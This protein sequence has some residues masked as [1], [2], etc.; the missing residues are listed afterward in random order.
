MRIARSVR[1]ICRPLAVWGLLVHCGLVLAADHDHGAS[2][3][4]QPLP[5][6]PK[7]EV[8]ALLTIDEPR[9]LSRPIHIVWLSGPE[10]HGGGEHDYIRIQETFV[11]LLA[12]IPGVTVEEAYR[13]P[14]TE[15][16]QRC[17]LL[18]QY[19]HLPNLSDQQFEMFRGYVLRGGAVFSI[20]E[21]CIMRPVERA[22]QLAGCLGAAW[23]GDDVSEWSKFG[24]DHVLYLDTN[25]PAFAGLPTAFAFN[26]ESYWDLQHRPGFEVIAAVV[27]KSTHATKASSAPTAFSDLL[28]QA[29]VRGDAFW[30]YQLGRGRV[31]G[32][33][34]GHYTYTFHDPRYRVLMMRCIAWA[35]RESPAPF[36]SLVSAGISSDDGL[37]GTTETMLEYENRQR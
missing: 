37:V 27:P 20:H 9:P 34:T 26:D 15:Q 23:N 3:T 12:E 6:L 28:A 2:L 10:D 36:H 5:P 8:G 1:F 14:S 19:L 31:I 25:H 11:P 21:S 35:L 33:T 32:T 30:T 17:D 4:P 29:D 7:A 18:I 22:T 16:F 24:H 13:F